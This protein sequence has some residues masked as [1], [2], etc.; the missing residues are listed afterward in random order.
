M[1]GTIRLMR[2]TTT[3]RISVDAS[4]PKSSEDQ[5][6]GSACGTSAYSY[7][8]IFNAYLHSYFYLLLT[9]METW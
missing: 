1:S 2:D 4:V 3:G 9:H 8:K 7:F 5:G 6:T